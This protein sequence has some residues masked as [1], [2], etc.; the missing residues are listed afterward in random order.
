M[1]TRP[2]NHPVNVSGIF[3][4]HQ[5]GSDFGV[6][7][8][9]GQRG[10]F[11]GQFNGWSRRDH[12]MMV[13]VGEINSLLFNQLSGLVNTFVPHILSRPFPGSE[14]SLPQETQEML[15]P[16]GI[17]EVKRGMVLMLLDNEGHEEYLG[18]LTPCCD[19]Q[20]Y[21]DR[22]TTHGEKNGAQY[23]HTSSALP[24]PESKPKK[25]SHYTNPISSIE[26]V[27]GPQVK[28]IR[29]PIIDKDESPS[30]GVRHR[31]ARRSRGLEGQNVFIKWVGW[32][33][34]NTLV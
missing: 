5:S 27:R 14:G 4:L 10:Q 16:P 7:L 32:A 13:E 18:S 12:A 26:R 30:V 15:R 17:I 28:R 25:R 29:G 31:G 6:G 21:P 19:L 22:Q 2:A 34:A 33:V 3:Q 1:A 24:D 20:K 8:A 11:E 9:K 23:S